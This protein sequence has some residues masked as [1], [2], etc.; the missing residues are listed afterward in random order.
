MIVDHIRAVCLPVTSE[1]RDRVDESY[2]VTSWKWDLTSSSD[3]LQKVVVPRIT[4]PDCQRIFDEKN[5]EVVLNN[6]H[7]CTEGSAEICR[8]SAGAPLGN[9][10][11][12][13]G[14]RFVQFGF[15]SFGSLQCEDTSV[16][17]VYTRV[18]SYMDWITNTI[19]P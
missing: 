11:L 2:I 4:V 9:T 18:A 14:E 8:G 5:A 19:K 13:N 15:V 10:V 1:L 7:I 17:E 12:L 6:E 3:I 16:P